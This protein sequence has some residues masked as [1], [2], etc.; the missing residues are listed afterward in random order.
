MKYIYLVVFLL[1]SGC[2]MTSSIP[3][4]ISQDNTNIPSSS[5]LSSW[6]HIVSNELI[7]RNL[8]GMI[9]FYHRGLWF[10]IVSQTDTGAV[11]WYQQ[12]GFLILKQQT[13]ALINTHTGAWLYH[14]AYVHTTREAL[15]QRLIGL[16][17]YNTN[18]YEWSADHYVS[19]AFYF[20]DPEWNG[21]ELYYDKDPSTWIWNNGQVQM[22]SEYIDINAYI[23]TYGSSQISY[24]KNFFVWHNHLQVWDITKAK[25][26]YHEVLW[27][28]VTS[29]M[30]G[31]GALFVSVGW[32][33]HHFGLNVWNSNGAGIRPWSQQWLGTMTLQLAHS[34]DI[35]RLAQRLAQAWISFEQKNQQLI[36]AD[37][38]G[39]I[40]CFIYSE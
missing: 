16:F 9:D 21:I 20:H 24:D 25:R 14:I 3:D 4:T 28:D 34:D 33:H 15:A 39:N 10:D 6:L 37:P 32:Y 18:V 27:F 36:V 29:D 8:S 19:E 30:S 26:F 23:R 40:L 17:Q 1:L 2:T 22:W 12:T 7:V 38:W 11:L 31:Q 13:D 5:L 35:I